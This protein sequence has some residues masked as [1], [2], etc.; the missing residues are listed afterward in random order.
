MWSAV[1]VKTSVRPGERP[2][3]NAAIVLPNPGP[4]GETAALKE[5]LRRVGSR[6][7]VLV[8]LARSQYRLRVMPEP[9]VPDR[10]MQASLRWAAAA[11]SDDP[12]EELNLAW[13]RIPIDDDMSARP[14]QVY[15]MTVSTVWLAAQLAVWKQAG[16][17]PKVVDVRETALRNVAARLEQG[18]DGAVLVAPDDAGV[19]MVFTHHGSLY[20]DRYFRQPLAEWRAAAPD[21]RGRLLERVIGQVLR[22]IDAVKRNFPFVPIRRVVVAPAPEPVGLIEALATQLPLPVE[23]L[24][25]GRV[26]DLSGAT[27]LAQTPAIQSCCLVAL[28]ATL[29]GVAHR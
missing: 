13:M 26:F 14:R 3:V 15:A 18:D 10:E 11:E 19:G 20:F 21:A 25:L 24:D 2:R 4:D 27:D 23:A 28:G 9:P 12:H 17:K 1:S 5:M 6:I 22:S 7:P 29:R 8:T 16:L